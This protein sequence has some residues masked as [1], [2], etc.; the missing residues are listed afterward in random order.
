MKRLYTLLFVAT[1]LAGT[2]FAAGAEAWP[3]KPLRAVVPVAAGSSTDIVP[4]VVFEQ[5]AAQLGQGIVVENRAGAGGTIGSAQVARAMPDG[6][7]LLAHG[8]AHTIAPALY[9]QLGYDPVRDFVAV[10]PLG[11]S[12]S[13]LVVAPSKGY[14]TVA[15]LVAAAKRRP[16]ELNFSSVGVGSATHL[17]AERFRL[18]AG[19][20]A[21]HVPYKGGAEAMTDAITG[22]VDF[23]F[24]PVA[25]VLPQIRE[26][27]LLA[28]AVNGSRRAAV[29]PDVPTLH[30][31][32]IANAEYPIWFGIFAPARTPSDVVERLNGEAL[33][34]LQA[35]KVRDR[36]ASLGVEPM[37][38]TAV[39]FEAFVRKEVGVNAA[40]VQATGVKVE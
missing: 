27:K 7:T 10:V 16:G 40:L 3:A 9:P 29:L 33:Q 39:E 35:P 6:Y 4:R 26:G 15:D 17:S 21:Q 23:F 34:A 28:L 18:S 37:P 2:T 8:S 13:V 20:S 36:L 25:L 38:M 14:R 32:G 12:P 30:E 24:G 31:A 1:A 11:V 5:L 19:I 22:R